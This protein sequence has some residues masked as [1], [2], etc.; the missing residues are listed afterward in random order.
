M[1][2]QVEALV[3][4]QVS[5][6]RWDV[7]E[8]DVCT[9]RLQHQLEAFATLYEAREEFGCLEKRVDMFLETFCAL[10]APH[11]PELVDIGTTTALD[12][13]VAGIELCVVEF[14]LL[15]EISGIRRV[16]RRQNAF[17]TTKEC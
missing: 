13:L 16:A 7:V 6:L 15:E 12:V 17:V 9:L 4:R 10:R 5:K 3:A 11:V 14:V 8:A 1:Q 2:L